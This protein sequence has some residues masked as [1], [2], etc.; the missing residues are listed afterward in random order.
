MSV[1]QGVGVET[2]GMR[3][4]VLGREAADAVEVGPAAF[5]AVGGYCH[6]ELYV[7]GIGGRNVCAGCF[8]GSRKFF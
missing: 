4:L 8:D 7:F 5:A 1:F 3:R 6:G 2:V